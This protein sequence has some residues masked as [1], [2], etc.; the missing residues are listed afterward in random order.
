MRGVKRLLACFI[1]LAF[2]LQAAGCGQQQAGGKPKRVPIKVAFW[3]S[4]EEIEIIT[5]TLNNWQ[6]SHPEIQVKLEHIPFGSYV[7]KILT[8]IAGRAAPDIIAA[9]VNMFVSFADKDVFLDLNPYVEKDGTFNLGDFFPEVVDRYTVNGKV[10]AIPRDTA[11]MAC[12]YYNKKLFDEAGLPYP[13]DDWD[14]NDLLD[15]AKKLTKFDKDGKVTQYGFYSDMWPNFV[16]CF[17]GKMSDNVKN[18]KKCLLGSKESMEG[19]Q[20][21]VDLSQKYKVSPTSNTFRNQGLGVIQMFMMQRVAMFHSGIWETPIVKKVKDFDWDVAMFPKGPKG[22]RKFATGGTGYGILKSTKYPDEAWEVLKALSGDDGQIMLAE[23]GLAQP[24]NKKI[25]EGEHFAL[26]SNVPLNKKMLNE[27]VK[28]TVYDP[29]HAK[30]REIRDLYIYPEFDLMFNGLKP[31]K[32][33]VDAIVP[34]ANELFNE[35]E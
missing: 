25:A 3:G 31:V 15:K 6:K 28:M 14:M 33:A 1:I 27:A 19:L 8:E 12:V 23:S 11:P 10:L 17:G 16:M 35:E 13:T 18:P 4:P 34:K 22:I 32:D 24:A 26:S 20:F 29:F 9:E 21:L 5:T 30:W 2:A 7:S